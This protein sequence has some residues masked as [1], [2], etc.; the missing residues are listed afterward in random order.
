MLSRCLG[1]RAPLLWL[2]LP[3]MVGL[4]AGK[5]AEFAPVPWLLS[6]AVLAAVV[7]VFASRSRV[8]LFTGSV[9]LAMFLAGLASYALHRPRIEAWDQL[10]PREVRLSLRIDRVFNQQDSRRAGGLG[11]IIRADL[12]VEEL[13]GQRV[14]FS[15][16][17]GRGESAPVRSSVLSTMGVL[18][19]LP[20]NPPTTTFDGYLANAGVNFRLTRARVLANEKP[21]SA[22]YRFCARQAQRFSQI[23]GGGIATKRPD[24]VS[25]LRAM[26]LGQQNELN[27]EQ[28]AIFRQSGTMHVFSISGLHIAVIATGLQAL[29]S[30]LRLPRMA[31]F[32]LGLVALWLYVDITGAAPSAVRAFVM[33]AVVEIALVLRLP[34]NPLSALVASA[35]I[36]LL[37]DPL[38]MFSASFQMSYGIV[39]ALLLLGLPLADTLQERCALFRDLPKVT[40]GW[41]R[42]AIDTGWRALLSATAI[43]TAASLVSAITGILFFDL[44]TPGA[45]LANLW[46]I[47]AS[48]VAI[49]MGML[50]LIFGLIGWI[51][52]SALANHAAALVLWGVDA[53]IRRN[54]DLPGMW[55]PASF[56]VDAAG[57]LIL[58]LLLIAL[59]HGYAKNWAGWQRAY[60]TPFVIVAVALGFGVTYL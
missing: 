40:W 29:L 24:L 4:A 20:R 34:R 10:P 8:Y 11:T 25:V 32:A 52:A 6:G 23:L 57:P 5:V 28:T 31:Q 30:L 15:L 50:S 21:A 22:Y 59:M 14:Y 1:H 56:K 43:G 49:Y 37:V 60:W 36:I 53:S 46:L 9:A 12:P 18:V 7:A 27:E 48:S 47:P 33:V 13:A 26:L 55:Y 3:L 39:A 54:V 58:S 41:H 44:F 45:F 19:T 16:T 35:M 51:A 42:S 2:V 38:Q 17:M